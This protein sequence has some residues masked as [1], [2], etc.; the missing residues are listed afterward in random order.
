MASGDWGDEGGVSWGDDAPWS[1]G[2]GSSWGGEVVERSSESWISRIGKAFVAIPIGLLLFLG[3]FVLLFWNEG[4]AVKTA[5]GL[6]EGKDSVV[7]AAP[8]TIDPENDGKLVHLTGE[9]T[10]D[11]TL[12]DPVFGVSARAISLRRVVEMYQ[13]H[14]RSE[15]RTRKKLGGGRERVTHYHYEKKW[16]GN[17]IQSSR[18]KQAA[19]HANPS[20]WPLSS[21]TGKARRVALGA[22]TLPEALVD[23]IGGPEPLAVGDSDR[24]GLPES[25]AAGLRLD[26]GRFYRGYDPSQPEVG[27]LRIFFERVSPQVM[28]VLAR[29]AGSSLEPFETQSGASIERIQSG[30]LSAAEMFQQAEA[31][32]KVLTWVLRL[33]GFLVMA[34]GLMMVLSPLSVLADI[35]PF[36]G[37]IVGFGTGFLAFGAAMVLSLATIAISWIAVRPVLG[38]GLLVLA[39][40]ALFAFLRRAGSRRSRPVVDPADGFRTA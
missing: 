2:E 16:S 10:V 15:T 35:V 40:L 34:V 23:Q 18:F 8:G 17:P 25:V 20:D 13:W 26:G 39:A 28:S 12:K 22:F 1:G 7:S 31:E 5:N 32:N 27:D 33:V 14:E 4:R 30:A 11:E 6:E 29:Q 19:G 3:S 38:I 9:A 24:A 36:L 37:T 21:W